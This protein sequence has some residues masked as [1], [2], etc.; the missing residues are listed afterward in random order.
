MPCTCPNTLA[1]LYISLT[2]REVGAV[3]NEAKKKKAKCLVASHHLVPI[4][5]ESFGVCTTAAQ[6]F[7]QDLSHRC[8]ALIT[9]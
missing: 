2:T 1:P 3:T 5:V 9:G 6:I 4:A 8:V 7:L